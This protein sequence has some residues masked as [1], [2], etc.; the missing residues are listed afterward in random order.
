M[1]ETST[2]EHRE[3]V[4]CLTSALSGEPISF[5]TIK[6]V[7]LI[8]IKKKIKHLQVQGIP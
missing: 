2:W 8:I 6:A 1:G 4:K 3:V 5:V 7:I